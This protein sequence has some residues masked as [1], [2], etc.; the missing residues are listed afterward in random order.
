MNLPDYEFYK[1]HS[2]SEAITAEEW[3]KYRNFAVVEYD[4]A[5]KNYTQ[6]IITEDKYKWAICA[7]ADALYGYDVIEGAMIPVDMDGNVRTTKIQIGSISTSSDTI[8]LAA[9]GIDMSDQGRFAAYNWILRKY[10][11]HVSRGIPSRRC[12]YW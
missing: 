8:D 2:L 1:S 5:A 12:G 6:I 11:D 3:D 7:I 9:A 4:N 10:A